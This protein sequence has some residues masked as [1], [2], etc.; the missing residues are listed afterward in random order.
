M[1]DSRVIRIEKQL[2]RIENVFLEYGDPYDFH[3]FAHSDHHDRRRFIQWCE[4]LNT[5]KK[6]K[7][8]IKN[9][10]SLLEGFDTTFEKYVDRNLNTFFFNNTVVCKAKEHGLVKPFSLPI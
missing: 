9:N 7:L 2:Q 6:I 1:K 4:F 3:E 5:Y 8:K 10:N